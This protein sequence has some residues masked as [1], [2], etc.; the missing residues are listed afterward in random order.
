[1]LLQRTDRSDRADL[2]HLTGI[3][4]ELADYSIRAITSGKDA[5][6]EVALEVRAGDMLEHGRSS[7]TDILDASARAY[8]A[9]VNRIARRLESGAT[10]AKKPHVM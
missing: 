2:A 4:C 8:V 9:A 1:M 10:G 5:M 7:S 3:Q 6:G